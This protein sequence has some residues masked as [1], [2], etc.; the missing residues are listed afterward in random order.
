MRFLHT[1]DWQI[2]MKAAHAGEQAQRVRDARLASA[3]RVME[4]AER[5]DAPF[6]LVAGDTFEDSAV[7]RKL[8]E[9]VAQI[10]ESGARRVYIL[11]GNH[12]PLMPGSVWEHRVWKSL[13]HVTLLQDATPISVEG[14]VL[15]SAPLTAK[16][17][18]QNP[19]T[20]IDAKR[21]EEICIGI[22]HGSL[23]YVSSDD[24]H[25]PMPKTAAI[26]AGL[27]Y[28]AIGHWHSTLV[29]ESP[30]ASGVLA[31]SGTHEPTAFGERDSGNVLLVDIAARGAKPS[32][33]TLKT[34]EL[35][36]HSIEVTLRGESDLTALG[37]RLRALPSPQTTLLE[38]KIA[39]L[40][41]PQF[42][43]ELA[44][45][46]EKCTS[47][48]LLARFDDSQ[49]HAPPEDDSWLEAIPAGILRTTSEEL[50][51]RTTAASAPA[52]RESLV[53][54]RALLELFRLLKE[55]QR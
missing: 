17:G 3:R 4:V 35:Q 52:A 31:Y 23:D 43:S 41:S 28:L 20:S 37:A 24:N 53:A 9:E 50:R 19:V 27:D 15:F 47:E 7:D 2:G 38:C 39:G 36:W 18:K 34:G 54:E 29:V 46:M 51:R 44:A 49:L 16:H 8:V 55:S 32:I 45:I 11:P 6:L 30:G 21:R 5:E 42:R 22:A 33:K 25:F 10:L 1:A 40:L 12:D 26:D 14:G 13:R 48:L